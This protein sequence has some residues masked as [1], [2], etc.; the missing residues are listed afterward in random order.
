MKHVSRFDI[1]I[2][3]SLKDTNI[4]PAYQPTFKLQENKQK[5]WHENNSLDNSF[6]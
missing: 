6:M 1:K 2:S 4:K 3:N 5:R